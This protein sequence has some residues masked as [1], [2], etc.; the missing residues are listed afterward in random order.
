MKNFSEINCNKI[1]IFIIFLALL[2]AFSDCLLFG[3]ESSDS[4]RKWKLTSIA[5]TTGETPLSS[6]L[7]V[8]IFASNGKNSA[9]LCYN[10]VLGQIV[11][12][13][14]LT[15]NIIIQPSGGIYHNIP[16]IGPMVTFKL[17]KNQLT[18]NHWFGWSAGI[19]EEEEASLKDIIFIYSFQQITY[20]PSYLKGV[21]KGLDFYYVLFH[22][23]TNS[24]SHML[25]MK[26]TTKFKF[27][28]NFTMSSSVTEYIQTEPGTKNRLLWSLGFAYNF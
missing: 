15:K 27:S 14:P 13:I 6:G 8:D 9:W 28:E 2:L 26:K 11:Y 22:Y 25:G 1:M 7:N 18:T 12:D 24:A 16:W 10:G 21:L 4:L 17:F 19:P 23:E 5:L 3:Q 20:S